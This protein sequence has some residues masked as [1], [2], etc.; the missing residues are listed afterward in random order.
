[1]PPAPPSTPLARWDEPESSHPDLVWWAQLDHRYLV[2]A[3]RTETPGRADLRIFD[4]DHGDA[5]VAGHDVALT[6]ATAS[7]PCIGDVVA[8]QRLAIATVDGPARAASTQG[9][10][11]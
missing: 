2:E 3:V 1:M 8:W 11:K 7:G 10:S 5:L 9:A 4:H 6:G